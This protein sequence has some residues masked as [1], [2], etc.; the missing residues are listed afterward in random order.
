VISIKY[1]YIDFESNDEI[2]KIRLNDKAG[3]IDIKGKELIPNKYHFIDG[4]RDGWAI[5]GIADKYYFLFIS[6]N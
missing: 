5:G 4:F 2:F 3:I 6:K 1:D